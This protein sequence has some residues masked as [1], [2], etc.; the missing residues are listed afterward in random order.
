MTIDTCPSPLQDNWCPRTRDEVLPSVLGLLPP[1]PAWEA[2]QVSGTVQN[3]YWGALSSVLGYTY[4]R[5]CAYT[6]EFFCASINE[7]MDQ[8]A[9]EFG[10][11]EECGPYANDLCVKV[12]SQGGATCAY[13]T[14]VSLRSGWV[15]E[16]HDISRD[17]E[18]I[19]GCFQVGCTPLGPTPVYNPYASALGYGQD[20]LC[21]YGEVVHHPDSTKWENGNTWDAICVVPGSNLGQGPN[22]DADESCCFIVGYYPI[23]KPVTDIVNDFCKPDDTI[24]FEC[25]QNNPYEERF[26]RPQAPTEGV[27]DDNH[28][29]TEWGNA[30]VWQ[31]TVDLPASWSLQAANARA[32]AAADNAKLVSIGAP[33]LENYT[34]SEAGNLMA[35]NIPPS[36]LNPDYGGT[37]LCTG[38]VEPVGPTYV[39]CFLN[40]IKPAHT[41]LIVKVIQP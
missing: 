36:T 23:E 41:T 28:N 32:A 40:S 25:P 6:D 24:Y 21:D 7:S 3:Q 27:F 26:L 2:A 4:G 19:A 37:P 9:A 38:S 15:V 12:A 34:S 30:F 13:F 8:W 14:Q 39:L 16:C 31:I 1:G 11:G 20:S 33:T 18:P 17:P 29:Y 10:M 5:L 35:G 22:D